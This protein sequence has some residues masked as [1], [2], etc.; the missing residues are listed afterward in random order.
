M[1]PTHYVQVDMTSLY[2]ERQGTLD[3]LRILIWG[4]TVT[5]TSTATVTIK[6]KTYRQVQARYYEEKPDGS[7]E[8]HDASDALIREDALDTFANY[9]ILSVSFVDVQQ[10]DGA[11]I[12]SPT[13]QKILIDGGDNQMFARYLASR[14]PGTS[15][16]A[17]LEVDALLVTHGD[18]D[19]FAGL[20]EIA[21]SENHAK[22]Y[23]RLFLNPRRVYHNGLVK[24]PSSLPETQQLG[25]TVPI[26]GSDKL[27]L[28]E[29][30]NDLTVVPEARM[31]KFFRAWKKALIHWQTLHHSPIQFRHLLWGDDDAFDFFVQPLQALGIKAQAKVLGPFP[32]TAAGATGLKFLGEP[33]QG[34]PTLSDETQDYPGNS[35][36]HTING[37]SVI[38]QLTY[39]AFR[40]LFAGD[41]NRDA[42]R[43]LTQKHRTGALNLE[44]EILKVPHHGSADFSMDF[45]Q[46][47]HPLVSV[48]SSG[49][50]S[51]R[52]EYIHP[53]AN[54]MAALGRASRS[55]S[56]LIFV[57]ELV[58][59]FEQMSWSCQASV[60][61][62][63]AT[64]AKTPAEVAQFYGFRRAAYG[65]V[66]VRT[67]GEHL[68]V[69]TDS[70]N[71]RMK[72]IY[73]FQADGASVTLVPVRRL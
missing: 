14:F 3:L 24:G 18:A 33:P 63:V 55:R 10:G 40:F 73:R 37:H 13:R 52:K 50:E 4:D 27:L 69:V 41:L 28:T 2:R 44:S 9:R 67:D 35:V 1:N 36:S 20:A 7:I 42:E 16:A 53:R 25:Q 8:P 48:V 45:L 5:A 26:P 43:I 11:V 66:K 31:N 57:T 34:D 68:L 58:A 64:G 51:A 56:P 19:H 60:L 71:V 22:S 49:D 23:K 47:V 39:G 62:E 15:A 59:F 65:L 30:H 38:L 72:E 21:D 17:P 46:A 61:K 6:G 12:E 29:L 70:A 54:L 32:T